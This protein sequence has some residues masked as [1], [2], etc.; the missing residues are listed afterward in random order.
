MK[1]TERTTQNC[2]WRAA[3]SVFVAVVLFVHA[4]LEAEAVTANGALSVTC[5]APYPIIP[6]SFFGNYTVNGSDSNVSIPY[7]FR[8][9]TP[10]SFRIGRSSSTPFHQ[11]VSGIISFR[12]TFSIA[13]QIYGFDPSYMPVSIVDVS[14]PEGVN[15]SL[16]PADYS[17]KK[18]VVDVIFNFKNFDITFASDIGVTFSVALTGIANANLYGA[19]YMYCLASVATATDYVSAGLTFYDSLSEVDSDVAFFRTTATAISNSVSSIYAR[20]Y[21]INQNVTSQ[22]TNIIN[23]IQAQ[24]TADAANTKSITDKLQSQ[25]NNDNSNS[26]NQVNAANKNS[27]NEIGAANAN[28]KNEIDAANKNAN[29][30]MHDYD[31]T[32]Q[33]TDN[34]KFADSQKQLQDVED[35][36]FGQAVSGFDALD[37]SDYT[38]GHLTTVLPAFSFV[39]GFIQSL[40]V[41][42]GDFGVIVTVGLVVM[43]ATKVIGVY[44][45]STGGDG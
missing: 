27:Q 22:A 17:P 24:M 8:G 38:I 26:T 39:S 6:L 21:D 20:L 25:I 42:M 36:L 37:M 34:K 4:P 9:E 44:R 30:I 41:K 18:S 43:I 32:S 7:V 5:S 23:K 14:A 31:T 2:I 19:S 16:R 12:V 15:V 33:D 29:D 28:S 11:Y 40:F 10:L 1:R 3:L 13:G 35:N 45:F